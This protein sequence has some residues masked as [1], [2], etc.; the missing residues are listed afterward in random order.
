MVGKNHAAQALSIALFQMLDPISR[1][2][3]FHQAADRL[4][5]PEAREHLSLCVMMSGD[6]KANPDKYNNFESLAKTILARQNNKPSETILKKEIGTALGVKESSA[7]TIVTRIHDHVRE[8]RR[9]ELLKLCEGFKSAANKLFWENQVYSIFPELRAPDVTDSPVLDCLQAIWDSL[10]PEEQSAACDR[11][12]SYTDWFERL[13]GEPHTE[14]YVECCGLYDLLDEAYANAKRKGRKRIKSCIYEE[15]NIDPDTYA[16]YE[17]SWL[18]FERRGC[19]GSYPSKRLSRERL[20]YL[21][22]VLDMDFYTAAAV[23]AKAGYAFHNE[24]ADRAAAGYLLKRGV[25]KD[26]ALKYLH[27]TVK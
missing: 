6:L 15:L 2:A 21:A 16:A 5:C 3:V 19:R 12:P 24:K 26:E 7:N 17:K 4:D 1:N 18:A 25:S 14:E 11:F 23:L 8:L 10:S 9:K 27:P 20:L 13:K 22:V